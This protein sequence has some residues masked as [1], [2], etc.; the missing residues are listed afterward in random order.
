MT[1]KASFTTDTFPQ[2][3]QVYIYKITHDTGI[4]P[5]PFGDYCTLAHCMQ[6]MCQIIAKDIK[7]FTNHELSV[8][9][10]GIWVI[11]IAGKDLNFDGFDRYGRIV[12]TM[13]IT[14]VLTFA[15]YWKDPRFTYKRPVLTPDQKIQYQNGCKNNY[16]FFRQNNSRQVCG[17]NFEA[18]RNEEHK[19]VLISD[20]FEYYGADSENQI[21]IIDYLDLSKN[22]KMR[23]YR[24]Y[25]SAKGKPIPEAVIDYIKHTFGARK[26][27]A[28]PTFSSPDF[29]V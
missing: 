6:D 16:S 25:S 12:Y 24:V 17:D 23:N 4:N 21:K 20:R 10:M 28:R 29:E 22:D 1:A 14:E 3:K 13:Q 11:G 2:I 27:L 8:A 9:D 26:C 19:H 5:N 7:K 15:E 18:Y